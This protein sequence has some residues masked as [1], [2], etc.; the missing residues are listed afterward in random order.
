[1][2]SW[3]AATAVCAFIDPIILL[4]IRYIE[5]ELLNHRMASLRVDF[6]NY[7]LV[8]ITFSVSI[9]HLTGDV[10]FLRNR[11]RRCLTILAQKLRMEGRLKMQI[12]TFTKGRLRSAGGG[13]ENLTHSLANRR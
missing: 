13:G 2:V 4:V 9:N 6:K 7:V 10:L 8:D 1:M 5:N 3:M 12:F 11:G